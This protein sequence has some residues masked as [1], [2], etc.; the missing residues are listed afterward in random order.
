MEQQTTS[1]AGEIC[2]EYGN[3]PEA[4][5]EIL[6]QL[7]A[8]R[9]SISEN[10]QRDIASALNLSRAEVHGV[11]SFYH[12][13]HTKPVGRV[14]IKVCRAEACQSLGANQLIADLVARLGISMG[15]T[16]PAGVA[17]E[18]VYCLGNCALAPAAMVGA[19]LVGR[20]DATGLETRASSLIAGAAQ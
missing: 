14:T 11:V 10:D 8:R 3:R 7:Q 19:N 4:L 2:A 9:G 16:N 5:I 18:A 12:D 20:A 1:P 6:H 17:V 13:F 15:E